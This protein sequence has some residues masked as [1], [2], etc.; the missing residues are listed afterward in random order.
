M[1]RAVGRVMCER[2]AGAIVNIASISGL[3][4]SPADN[5]YGVAKAGL[6]HLTK[7]MAL[8]FAT[9]G[10]RVNAIAPGIIETPLSVEYVMST[11]ERRERALATVPLGFC[12]Q[13]EDI[14][15]AV[16]FLVSDLA[17]YVTGVCLPVDGGC[18]A[19]NFPPRRTR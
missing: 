14:G 13:P 17:R 1:S 11:D 3:V 5:D 9:R 8:D 6:V 19:G 10:V 2:G 18:S 15:H 12:G 16:A 4:G 7:S